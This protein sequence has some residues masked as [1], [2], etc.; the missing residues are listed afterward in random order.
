VL[1][2]E[3]S[4]YTVLVNKLIVLEPVISFELSH[5]LTVMFNNSATS[6]QLCYAWGIIL[7]R[8]LEKRAWEN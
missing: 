6:K 2:K 4:L 8:K 1:S 5:W 3:C 7:V